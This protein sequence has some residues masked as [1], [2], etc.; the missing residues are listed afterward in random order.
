MSGVK[1]SMT[2]LVSEISNTQ[3]KIFAIEKL[4]AA[5][6]VSLLVGYELILYLKF[7]FKISY[8]YHVMR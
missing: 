3:N 7:K 4:L 6:L 1:F 5:I 2:C 8:F